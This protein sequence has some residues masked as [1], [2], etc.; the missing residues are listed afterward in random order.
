ML[1]R[2][3]FPRLAHDLARLLLGLRAALVHRVLQGF[4]RL[5]LAACDL[6]VGA[7]ELRFIAGLR[8]LGLGKHSLGVL[9]HL[10]IV[11]LAAVH[12]AL[13]RLVEQKIHRAEQDDE[14]QRMQQNLLQID[15][16]RHSKP[17]L[18]GSVLHQR[19]K[20]M[21]IATIRA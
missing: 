12:K 4:V 19:T 13:H 7:L 2:G 10:L 14:V 17:L 21:R 5:A 15:I 16:K 11:R 8:L 3:I 9:V 20:I 18:F 6:L 1:A